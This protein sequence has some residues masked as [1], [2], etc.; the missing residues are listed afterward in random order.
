MLKKVIVY[1]LCVLAVW[2]L[3]NILYETWMSAHVYATSRRG[4]SYEISYLSNR[5]GF[6]AYFCFEVFLVI[7]VVLFLLSFVREPA[8]RRQDA[9][10]E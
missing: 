2:V 4:E 1:S 8:N 6:V 10:K 3:G 5:V 7:C 9:T